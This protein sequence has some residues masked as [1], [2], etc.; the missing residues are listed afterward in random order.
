MSHDLF[1][2]IIYIFIVTTAL[3]VGIMTDESIILL[4]IVPVPVIMVTANLI[5]LISNSK[6]LKMLDREMK[7]YVKAADERRAP[8]EPFD[9][10]SEQ[11]NWIIRQDLKIV[12]A[13][14]NRKEA[15]FGLCAGIFWLTAWLIF[16]LP[17][18]IREA[19]EWRFYF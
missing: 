15:I 9:T 2:A 1:R 10:D 13:S 3:I 19:S 12:F 5:K 18:I 11:A 6:K 4:L 14:S 17:V 7:E 8:D 16:C